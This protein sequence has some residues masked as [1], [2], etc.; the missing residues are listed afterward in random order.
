MESTDGPGS[1]LKQRACGFT[2]F[3]GVAWHGCFG[4]A[5]LL[6]GLAILATIPVV[7]FLVLGYML[8]A[9]A[10]VARTG[11]LRDGFIG[12][13]QTNRMGSLA[14]GTWL[15]L[16]PVRYVSDVWYTSY[17]VDP[18]SVVTRQWRGFLMIL[19]GLVLCQ[20]SWAW[21]RGGKLR[22]FMWPAP[23]RLVRE[24]FRPGKYIRCRDAVW[25]F[26]VSLRI[27][28]YFYLG[29]RGF[30]GAMIWLL[31]PLL[32]FIG[33][34]LLPFPF[35]LVSGLGGFILLFFIFPHLS[36]LQVHFAMEGSLGAMFDLGHIRQL[37]RRSPLMFTFA[38]TVTLLFAL[39][40]YLLKIEL[41]PSEVFVLPSLVFVV[42]IFPARLFTGWAVNRASQRQDARHFVF[43]W[44][45]RILTAAVVTA[46]ILFIFFTRYTSWHGHWSLL[47]QHA[48]MVPVPF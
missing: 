40:L 41:T 43:R 30:L 32:L 9:G 7:Q 18:E 15:L 21:F 34:T 31:V 1:W 44:T 42:F 36:F 25:D 20:V 2:R 33:A 5:S 19:T 22:H 16:W 13:Q 8:E 12:I 3:M 29:W 37:G 45:A 28:Y 17:L 47:E 39:P 10:R 6:L 24:L 4:L 26:Y 23:V 38:L 11:R 35:G 27:G 14:L 48:F 46:Y